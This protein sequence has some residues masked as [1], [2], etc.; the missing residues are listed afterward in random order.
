MLNFFFFCYSYIKEYLK[1]V[2]DK[3]KEEMS[4]EELEFYYFKLYDYDK[5]NKL[6]GVEIVKVI[7]YFY[8]E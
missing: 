2:V 5:N 3:F 1:D 6:D 7:I 4:E 8:G